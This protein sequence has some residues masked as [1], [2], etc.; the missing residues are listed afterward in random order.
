RDDTSRELVDRRQVGSNDRRPA[1]HRLEHGE[2]EALV[3]GDI[4][5]TAGTAV[6]PRE[7]VVRDLAQPAHT[8]ARHR[9]DVS[10]AT[11]ADDSKLAAVQVRAAEA[12]DE[13]AEVLARLE[14]R[15]G[16]HVVTLDSVP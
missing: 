4:C 1:R 3:E 10:P 8:S 6:Q 12:L 13:R 7:L 14:R 9:L 5:G 2:A 15:N 11:R 16:E